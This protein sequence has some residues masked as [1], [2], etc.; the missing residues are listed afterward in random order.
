VATNRRAMSDFLERLEAVG[1]GGWK[2]DRRGR[3][4]A[5]KLI[6]SFEDLEE[7]E[8]EIV[9]TRWLNEVTLY[10]SL[11]K[12]Q[13]AAYYSLR[14]PM[15][16]G[17][18]TVPVLAS[19]SVPQIATVLV[20]LMVAI[21]TALDGLFRLGSRWRQARLAE[22]KLSSEGWRF[23]ELSGDIY[24][25]TDRTV[26]YRAFLKRIELLN[27]QLSMTRLELFDEKTSGQAPV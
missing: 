15:V 8:R 27:E 19:L 7:C 14:I 3:E 21:L 1:G 18:T 11:W 6:N 17:A 25:G 5:E 9:Q 12:R 23:L 10:H 4:T 20:G 16:I 26:A 24:D 13:R 22:E 2:L